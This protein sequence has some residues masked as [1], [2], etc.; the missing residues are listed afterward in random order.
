MTKTTLVTPKITDE[1][2]AKILNQPPKTVMRWSNFQ[3]GL[4]FSQGVILDRITDQQVLGLHHK[5]LAPDYPTDELLE[6]TCIRKMWSDEYDENEMPIGFIGIPQLNLYAAL[7]DA[8][9]SVWWG[10]G[11]HDKITMAT[12]G[13]ELY[14]M[15]KLYEPFLPLRNLQTGKPFHASE[16]LN[17]KGKPV[18]WEVDMRKGNPSQKGKSGGAIAIIRGRFDEAGIVGHVDINIDR[19]SP[20]K[21]FELF[22]VCGVKQGLASARPAKKM[23]YGQFVMTHWEWVSGVDPAEG[24]IL[25]PTAAARPTRGSRKRQTKTVGEDGDG[26]AETRP[27]ASRSSRRK[28]LKS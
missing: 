7:R 15:I 26:A 27:T 28:S 12:K 14:H 9:E 16:L 21:V 1:Y 4:T 20:A 13:T 5:P 10:S 23:P 19:V 8:G 11:P 25:T 6:K 24:R 22:C 18:G 3:W 2:A 17:S